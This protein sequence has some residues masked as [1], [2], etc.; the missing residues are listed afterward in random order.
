MSLYCVGCGW[1]W[2]CPVVVVLGC[3]WYVV[4]WPRRSERR[5]G[6]LWSLGSHAGFLLTDDWIGCLSKGCSVVVVVVVVVHQGEA[7][8]H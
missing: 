5:A 4:G 6:T 1:L 7:L 2:Y 8:E 3:P